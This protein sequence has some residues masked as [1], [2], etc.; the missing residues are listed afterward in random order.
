MFVTQ[1][2]AYHQGVSLTATLAEAVNFATENDWPST[3]YQP[4]NPSECYVYTPMNKNEFVPVRC[5]C[6]MIPGVA[7]IHI[8]KHEYIERAALGQVLTRTMETTYYDGARQK[9]GE[10]L[11]YAR[12][13][14]MIDFM[15]SIATDDLFKLAESPVESSSTD[16][17]DFASL[18]K[19]IVKSDSTV[20][21]A[22]ELR[23][24]HL[25]GFYE[26]YE[27]L[28]RQ[29][30]KKNKGQRNKSRSQEFKKEE[31]HGQSQKERTF[32]AS[33]VKKVQSA[34]AAEGQSGCQNESRASI[35]QRIK[36]YHTQGVLLQMLMDCAGNDTRITSLLPGT[37]NDTSS[38]LSVS[39]LS[40][41]IATDPVTYSFTLLKKKEH[42]RKLFIRMCQT[43]RPGLPGA[44]KAIK[45]RAASI[46]PSSLL[47]H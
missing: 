26:K 31:D 43:L 24:L 32:L 42:F 11:G 6:Q 13:K 15:C 22:T 19:A 30:L 41:L 7:S 16:Q 28:H 23:Y 38:P 40:F 47:P 9:A 39:A 37:F 46:V 4:C 8:S 25:Y 27:E 12:A 1:P 21:H 18:Y 35:E 34:P 17:P 10:T 36:A 14:K 45:P 5:D 29:H 20:H 2:G 33:L 44:V 3:L